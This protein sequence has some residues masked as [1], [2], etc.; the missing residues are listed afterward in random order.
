MRFITIS[1]SAHAKSSSFS[2]FCFAKEMCS[3]IELSGGHSASAAIP[4]FQASPTA[5]VRAEMKYGITAGIY[6]ALKRFLNGN[7]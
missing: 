4:A 6:N 2:M 7:L 5:E 1:V 3:P